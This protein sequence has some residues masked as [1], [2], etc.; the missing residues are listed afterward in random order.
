[1]RDADNIQKVSQIEGIDWMGFIFTDK[2]KRY[3]FANDDFETNTDKK[4][5]G[6][7]VDATI[8]DVI[9]KIEKYNLNIVQ[10]HGEESVSYINELVTNE[11]A[12]AI[13]V[14]KAFAVDSDFDFSITEEYEDEVDYFLFD[15]KGQEAGGNGI[16][17]DWSVIDRYRG[18]TPFLLAGG[19]NPDSVDKIQ[20]FHHEKCVGIDV[21]SGF[22]AKPGLKRNMDLQAFAGKLKR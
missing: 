9:D 5:V 2:S 4:K 6:V 15:A 12:E 11:A 13:L 7:F 20:D 17:F 18:E 19:I 10:L 21:N 8:E 3:A 16:Q 1:M 22:E 14:M